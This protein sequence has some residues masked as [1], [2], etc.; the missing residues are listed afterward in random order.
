MV[1]KKIRV[2]IHFFSKNN[3]TTNITLQQQSSSNMQR[4]LYSSYYKECCA[5]A[6]VAM[7]LCSWIFGLPLVT[8]HSDDDQQIEQTMILQPSILSTTVGRLVFFFL[9]I[10]RACKKKSCVETSKKCTKKHEKRTTMAVSFM[11]NLK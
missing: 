10:F 4:A 8:G 2:L 5:K 1:I 9:N 6:G 11:L 7:Q 3:D